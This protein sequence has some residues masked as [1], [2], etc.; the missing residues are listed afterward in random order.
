MS[1]RPVRAGVVGVG[2][3]GWNHARV[4]DALPGVELVGV[5]DADESRAESVAS[6]L[7]AA[8]VTADALFE[9]ADAVTVAVPTQYHYDLARRALEAGVGVLVEKPFVE[10]P[11]QGRDLVQRADRNDAT[12]QVGHVER[13]N[14][15]V[16]A[17]E[18]VVEDLE[19]IAAHAERLTPPPDRDIDD[20]ATMDLMIHDIDLARSLV[21]GEVA[22]CGAFG[23]AEGRYAVGTL[24]FDTGVVCNLTASRVTREDVRRVTVTA[25]TCRVKAD[26]L[27]GTVEVHR[28][29]AAEYA[30]EVGDVEC[31]RED[32][33]E[34]VTVADA[35]PLERELGA[36]T[37][38]VRS[39]DAPPVTGEDGLRVLELAR[40]LE[41][42]RVRGGDRSEP[43]EVAQD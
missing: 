22:S 15:V 40:E 29:G 21:D 41:R 6:S 10:E 25:E 20:T 17:L 32:L 42:E 14:P 13:F 35:D 19:V 43:S 4:Y 11:A 33:V 16:E 38:A 23:T 30:G 8:A 36:F 39:G 18:R 9:R 2:S 27:E 31:R 24:Q 28:D 5:A 12:L 37:D 1:E 7:G 34:R 3:M 26:L